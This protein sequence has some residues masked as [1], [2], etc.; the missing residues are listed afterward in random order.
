MKSSVGALTK[1]VPSA[2]QKKRET[3]SIRSDGNKRQLT[4]P[5]EPT[6]PAEG[7]QCVDST[8]M[9]PTEIHNRL[10]VVLKQ[11]LSSL[12]FL[13]WNSNFCHFDS[14]LIL[15]LVSYCKLGAAYWEKKDSK[16]TRAQSH[17]ERQQLNLLLTFG[18][19]AADQMKALRNKWMW[20]A[21]N[22][23]PQAGPV[24]GER[25][26]ALVHMYPAGCPADEYHSVEIHRNRLFRVVCTD[27][28][29]PS[30]EM[31]G[32]LKAERE[33]RRVDKGVY[34]LL[35]VH[36]LQDAVRN[37][38]K[39]N[40]GNGFRCKQR[41][42]GV[43]NS[44]CPGEFSVS[45]VTATV[46]ALL[47]IDLEP[48]FSVD[49]RLHTE[50]ELHVGTLCYSLSGMALWNGGH[51]TSRFRVVKEDVDVWYE[52]DDL[53]P[54]PNITILHDPFLYE[55]GWAPRALWYTRT[56]DRSQPMETFV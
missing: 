29:V 39:H 21:L 6:H 35:Q 38:F 22:K 55:S 54:T 18:N 3:V 2:P 1:S 30:S 5:R 28:G 4:P 27:H 15:Q 50:R 8:R 41:I 36:T 24:Y 45:V 10:L 53:K 48:P 47:C 9:T 23:D 46:G 37:A 11:T 13:E 20:E 43:K 12:H 40:T 33:T 19:Y 25:V 42:T 32:C 7:V 16:T 26:D 31:S 51:Y 44:Q 56:S 17:H 34:R 14:V 49:L 52:Y